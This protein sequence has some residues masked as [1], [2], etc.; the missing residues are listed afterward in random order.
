MGELISENTKWIWQPDESFEINHWVEFRQVVEL[1][2]TNDA[3]F[4][5]AADT[6]YQLWINET[7]VDDAIFLEFPED[8]YYRQIDVSD[9]LKEGQN[10]I[11]VLGYYQGVNTSRHV[12]GK[13]GVIFELKSHGKSVLQSTSNCKRSSRS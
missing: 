6:A 12:A 10:C 9:Y 4:M 2:E 5:I 7:L 8:R 13:P 3:T 11:A 1:D